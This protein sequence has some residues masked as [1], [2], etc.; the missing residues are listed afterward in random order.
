VELLRAH[1]QTQTFARHTHEGYA[2][3]VIE[4]GA[5]GF[6]Y[7]GENVTAPAGH[8]NLC[9][10]GEVHTG[11]PATPAGWSYRMFYLGAPV[12]QQVAADLA[13]GPR[14]LPFFGPG[15]VDDAPLA[16]RLRE[17]HLR[18]EEPSTPLLEQQTL[19]LGVLAQLVRRHADAP[20]PLART[21]REPHAVGMIKRYLED[22][23]ADEVSLEQ[24]SRLTQLSRYH[25]V[26]VFREAVGVPPYAYLRQVRVG[27]AKE[28]LALG[29]SV[30]E[31]ALETGF[32]DQSH[33]HRWFKRLWGVTPGGYRNSVQDG[34]T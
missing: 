31:V 22:R 32:T 1:R 8:V 15:V 33:L 34:P 21:G 29:R 11:Q 4:G 16:R 20:P 13:D 25:L 30:A 6:F 23:Y 26:R 27:R 17:V 9:V 12:L 28:L 19:V 5:L 3:G 14:E 24:L 2:V 7:R 10:P 18:L